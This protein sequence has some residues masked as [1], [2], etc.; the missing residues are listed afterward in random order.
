MTKCAFYLKT[1]ECK[2]GEGCRFDHPPGEGGTDRTGGGR[3]VAGRIAQ[4]AGASS[5]GRTDRGEG[6]QT[7]LPVRPGVQKCAFFLK[8]GMCKYG[9]DCRWNHPP[10]K[11]TDCAM[12]AMV[13]LGDTNALPRINIGADVWGESSIMTG[14]Y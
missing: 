10:E 3:F 4:V 6:R 7:C 1:G 8:T 13:K 11:Q 14:V 12:A 2:Y 5:E 9:S